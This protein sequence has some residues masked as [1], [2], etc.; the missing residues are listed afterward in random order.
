MEGFAFFMDHDDLGKLPL[1]R[2]ICGSNNRVVDVGEKK[3]GFFREV[4]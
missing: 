2:K 1:Y 3:D 4:L